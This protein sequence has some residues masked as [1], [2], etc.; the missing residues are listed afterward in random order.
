MDKIIWL[1]FYFIF[2][3]YHRECLSD[4]SREKCPFKFIFEKFSYT[5]KNRKWKIEKRQTG[6][7]LKEKR[8]KIDGQTKLN[9]SKR[10][11]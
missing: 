4:N 8:K 2:G 1:K 6:G 3:I 9:D 7:K 5:L 10:R 11:E